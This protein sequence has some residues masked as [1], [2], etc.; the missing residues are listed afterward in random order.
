MITSALN[1]VESDPIRD[2]TSKAMD[3]QPESA[4]RGTPLPIQGDNVLVH[5]LQRPVSEAQLTECLINNDT[6]NQQE[7]LTV[8]GGTINIS[9][10]YCQGLLNS[11]TQ[12]LQSAGLDLSQGDNISVQIDLGKLANRGLT[13]GTSAKHPQNSPNQAMTHLRD[14]SNREDSDHPQKRLKK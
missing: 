4:N 13:S 1:P 9:S 12:A 8:E 2:A 14:V 6:L 10:V 11:L 7:D 5:L 3:R